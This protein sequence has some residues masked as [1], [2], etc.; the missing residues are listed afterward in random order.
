MKESL[1]G[2]INVLVEASGAEAS[3]EMGLP[4]KGTIH[5]PNV[6]KRVETLL[7]VLKYKH[8]YTKVLY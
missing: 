8:S 5:D 3:L 2:K 6:N 7:S 4:I 1:E